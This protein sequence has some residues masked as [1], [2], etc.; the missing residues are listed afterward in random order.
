[1]KP[2][3][4][5]IT[6]NKHI[7]DFIQEVQGVWKT[8]NLVNY[9][10]VKLCDYDYSGMFKDLPPRI[11]IEEK[12]NEV[13]VELNELN[14]EYNEEMTAQELRENRSRVTILN[15]EKDLLIRR[16]ARGDIV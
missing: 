16:R 5:S 3:D 14:N 15:K 11:T 10:Q 8:Y 7:R 4:G 6:F 1:M 12:L 13:N 2:R 9:K